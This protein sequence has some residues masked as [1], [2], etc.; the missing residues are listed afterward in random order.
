MQF[1]KTRRTSRAV[2]VL[3]PFLHIRRRRRTP[4]CLSRSFLALTHISCLCLC[5]RKQIRAPLWTYLSSRP[6]LLCRDC[7]RCQRV[8]RRHGVVQPSKFSCVACA[9]QLFPEERHPRDA[10]CFLECIKHCACLLFNKHCFPRCSP[11]GGPDS[12]GLS[13]ESITREAAH[14][15]FKPRARR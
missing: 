9:T 5:R 11:P 6:T 2:A 10:L 7:V 8:T 12:C 15:Y 13:P 1:D 4:R 3:W 14:C